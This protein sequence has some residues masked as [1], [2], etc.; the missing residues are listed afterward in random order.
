MKPQPVITTPRAIF[1]LAAVSAMPMIY[2]GCG[3]LALLGRPALDA[4]SRRENAEFIGTVEEV[5]HSRGELYLRTQ[6]GQSQIVTYTNRTQ[7]ILDGEET[8]ASAIERGDI[9]EVRMHGSAD[10]RAVADFI[11]VRERGQTGTTSIEG[12]VERVL[13]ERSVV[14]LRTSAGALISVYLPQNSPDII[15]D[16][17]SRLRSGDFVRFRGSFLGENRFESTGILTHPD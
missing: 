17:F 3:D 10:G 14:E 1:T 2:S 11:R 8:A 4:R 13:S 15:Q 12:A 7:I 6:G 5:D 9:I 16:E